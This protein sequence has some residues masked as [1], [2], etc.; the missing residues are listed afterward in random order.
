M[1]QMSGAKILLECLIK[2]GADVVFG[3]PGGAVLPLYDELYRYKNKIRHVLVRHEQGGAHAADGYARVRGKAG[4]CIGTS[5]P[6][7]TNLV[8]GIAAAMMDSIPMIVITGNVSSYLLGSDA[9]QETDITG[10]TQPIVKHSYLVTDPAQLTRVVKEAFYIA[11]TGRPGPVHI[12]ITKD[13]QIKK[14]S[15]LY[16]KKVSIPGYRIEPVI[17]TAADVQRAIKLIQ[18]AK[19]PVII[20]GHGVILGRAHEEL[21]EL[22]RMTDIPVVNTLLGLGSFPQQNSHWLGMLGMHGTA[23]AN[24]AVA[25]AD[26]VLGIGTRFDDRITGDLKEF[27]KRKFIH[28]EIDPAEFDK[29]VKANVILGGDVKRTLDMINAKLQLKTKNFSEWWKK[30]EGWRSKYQFREIDAEDLKRE[31]SK[32]SRKPHSDTGRA[33]LSG[34]T[35]T[36]PEVISLISYCTKG[37]G[38]VT[39]GVG[40]HQMF[41]AQ[42]YRVNRINGWVTS[43]GAGAMG[44]D[45][46]SAIGARLAAP[47]DVEVWAIV[48]DGGFQMTIQELG[49]ARQENLDIKIAVIND[50]YLGMVKQWQDLFYEK[51]LSEV[52]LVNPDFV[53]LA[54]AYGIPA[55]RI[56][57]WREAVAGVL[58]A[59]KTK[60]PVLLDFCVN[61]NQHVYPMVASGMALGSQVLDQKTI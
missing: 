34:R 24:Y 32:L 53:K 4:V 11:Q 40:Q 51:R 31:K 58:W 47:E 49:T 38:V 52:E 46:P 56:E 2:E 18:E 39:T 45:L 17:A 22:A 9:F 20:A 23:E 48:G 5:G 43:G 33:E 3:Y 12:D 8:T 16:P 42:Y 13:A 29:N 21:L 60:G 30:I 54:S 57:T 28:F 44:Y 37:M 61:P 15:F 55:R 35:L 36:T 27:Q 14:T 59:Q 10:I 50:G 6:G 41:A 25:E 7:A 1:K 19:R 26:L